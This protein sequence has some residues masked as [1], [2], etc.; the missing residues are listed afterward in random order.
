MAG[1]LMGLDAVMPDEVIAVQRP[2]QKGREL[3]GGN[4]HYF[5]HLILRRAEGRALA[6]HLSSDFQ[7]VITPFNKIDPSHRWPGEVSGTRK[8]FLPLA[9]LFRRAC[10]GGLDS[11]DFRQR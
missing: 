2:H 8:I 4:F 7:F 3:R 9:A 1:A 6:A 11:H 10:V 5:V